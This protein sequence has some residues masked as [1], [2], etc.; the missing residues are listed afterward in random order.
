M[1]VPEGPVGKIARGNQE[2]LVRIAYSVPKIGTVSHGGHAESLAF[3]GP[4]DFMFLAMFFVALYRFQMR[5]RET[6]LAIVPVL[7]GYLSIVLLAG[8][9]SFGPVSLAAMPALLPIGA[10][11]LIVNRRE[12]KL[13]KDEKYSSFLIIGVGLAVVT[14]RM[15]LHWHEQGQRPGLSQRV[16]GP[17]PSTPPGSR[18]P[19]G[20]DQPRFPT[21]PGGGNTPDPR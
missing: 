13:T 10:T 6:L 21:S 2:A 20:Q 5:T 17:G 9:V 1:F 16:L 15:S 19:I 7:A 8:H 18:T 4:A 11:V 3:V 12:F 14:W